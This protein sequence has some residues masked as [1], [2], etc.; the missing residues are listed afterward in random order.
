MEDRFRQFAVAR[1]PNKSDKFANLRGVGWG[2][3]CWLRK[4]GNAP[5]H[6]PIYTPR[7]TRNRGN[8]IQKYISVNVSSVNVSAPDLH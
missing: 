3:V 7:T 2:F 6:P 5:S 4:V 1:R 8:T